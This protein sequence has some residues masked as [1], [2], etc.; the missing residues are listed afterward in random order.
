MAISTH[1]PG[2]SSSAAAALADA[3]ITAAQSSDCGRR[4][5]VL[6][7]RA[8]AG[9]IV[10]VLAAAA[11]VLSLVPHLSIWQVVW[12]WLAAEF[13]FTF[14][15]VDKLHRFSVQPANQHPEKHDGVAMVKRWAALRKYFP[16]SESYL[17]TWFK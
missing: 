1:I 16:F 5:T 10:T 4:T 14:V 12:V 6:V 8:A 3:G 13:A 17:R 15:Y 2:E 7:L 11:A 9:A